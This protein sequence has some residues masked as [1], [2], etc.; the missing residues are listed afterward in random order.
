V[1]FVKG[2]NLPQLARVVA[3]TRNRIAIARGLG[4]RG[5]I[6]IV[7]TVQPIIGAEVVA[8]VAGPLIAVD[9]RAGRADESRSTR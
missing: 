7:I 9:A 2:E 4:I 3:E 6:Q 8:D 1:R 5:A